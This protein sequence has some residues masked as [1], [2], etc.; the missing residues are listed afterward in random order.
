MTIRTESP[1]QPAEPRH[2]AT[3]ILLREEG[4]EIEVLLTRRHE[5]MSFMGGLWVFPGGTLC[6]ADSS[7]AAL[8]LI[9]APRE[10]RMASVSPCLTR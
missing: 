2:A 6:P 8:A 3:V 10:S 4:G 5:Q 7:N 1:Q 9:A